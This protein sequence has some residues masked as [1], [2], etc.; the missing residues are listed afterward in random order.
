[1]G[2]QTPEKMAALGINEKY[3]RLHLCKA[4]AL[5]LLLGAYSGSTVSL[6]LSQRASGCVLEASLVHKLAHART[7]RT[8]FRRPGCHGLSHRDRHLCVLGAGLQPVE[9]L[10]SVQHWLS[11]ECA[12]CPFVHLELSVRLGSGFE[13]QEQS[14]DGHACP[15]HSRFTDNGACSYILCLKKA[16]GSR[17]DAIY[18]RTVS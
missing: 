10:H 5:L 3:H 17:S 4:A 6:L 1:M 9:I 11:S 12:D 2:L 16:C 15:C 8:A 13:V 14:E 18:A 7:V